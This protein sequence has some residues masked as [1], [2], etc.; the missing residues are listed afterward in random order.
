MKC[1]NLNQDNI[2]YLSPTLEKQIGHKIYECENLWALHPPW[3]L[4]N[5]WVWRC[6]IYICTGFS[7][8]STD[9]RLTGGRSAVVAKKHHDTSVHL[10][11]DGKFDL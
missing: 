9:P 6:L 2:G 7:S 10:N 8:K 1:F 11:T 3:G 4:R 5:V